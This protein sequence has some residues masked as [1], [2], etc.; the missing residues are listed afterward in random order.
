VW[1]RVPTG[2]EAKSG[3]G[4]CARIGPSCAST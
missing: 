3:V 2:C 4:G 1:L